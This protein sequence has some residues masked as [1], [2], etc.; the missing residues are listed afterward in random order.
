[1]H[2]LHLDASRAFTETSAP[3][4]TYIRW[5]YL[6]GCCTAALRCPGC[7]R[8][9]CLAGHRIDERGQVSPSVVCPHGCGFH[10]MMKLEGWS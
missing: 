9:F 6:P 7:G 3:T 10:V 1:M 4:G 5:L 8:L 2:T